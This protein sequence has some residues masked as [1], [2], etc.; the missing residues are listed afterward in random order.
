[1][2]DSRKESENNSFTRCIGAVTYV[3]K[4]EYT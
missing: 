3:S 4:E 1:M 2:G